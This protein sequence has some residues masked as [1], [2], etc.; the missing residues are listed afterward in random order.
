MYLYSQFHIFPLYIFCCMSVTEDLITFIISQ[1]PSWQAP[2][3]PSSKDK[4][5]TLTS[6]A[7]SL[8][9]T[10]L[11]KLTSQLIPPLM[12]QDAGLPSVQQVKNSI[13][14]EKNED[15]IVVYLKQLII[16]TLNGINTDSCLMSVIRFVMPRKNKALKKLL[17][18]YWEICPKYTVANNKKTLKH[19]MVL[20]VNALQHDLSS[21]NEYIRANTLRLIAKLQ[22]QELLEPL[23]PHLRQCLEHR[24]PIVKKLAIITISKVYLLY[25]HLIP[26]TSE[27]FF[28]VL[29]E[30]NDPIINRTILGVLFHSHPLL[31]VDHLSNPVHLSQLLQSDEN[32]LLLLIQILM[33]YS[34]KS[35]LFLKSIYSLLNSQYQSVQFEA[36]STLSTVT[37][38]DSI[39]KQCAECLLTIIKS[40]SDINVKLIVLNELDRVLNSNSI[41]GLSHYATDVLSCLNSIDPFVQSKALELS[42]LLV[43]GKSIDPVVQVLL[44]QLVGA[45]PS[46][47][48]V[49]LDT[50]QQL[51]V[52]YP[53]IANGLLG[54]LLQ[55]LFQESIQSPVT[56]LPTTST[57]TTS[58]SVDIL[59]FI[60]TILT[61]LPSSRHLVIVR[62][63]N[64]FNSIESGKVLRNVLWMLSEF[65][66]EEQLELVFNKIT[67]G[68]QN[69]PVDNSP[70]AATTDKA[71]INTTNVSSLLQ[72]MNRG[73]YFTASVLGSTL[74]KL[75]YKL[76]N[77]ENAKCKAMLSIS[78]ILRLGQSSAIMIDED[79]FD[80][81]HTCLNM[82]LHPTDE[83]ISL[84][85]QPAP[86][87][88][89][90]TIQHKM[91]IVK[92][93]ETINFGFPTLMDRVV[94]DA[95]I[96][97]MNSK[98]QGKLNKIIQLTGS[99]DDIYCETYV[100]V[101]LYDIILD[102]I[103]VNMTNKVLQ[104]VALEFST[105]GDL[106][107]I[108]K[109]GVFNIG[110][111]GTRQGMK[112]IKANIKVS[113][114]ETGV[115]FGNIFY[116]DTSINLVI[117]TNKGRDTR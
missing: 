46:F 110:P 4:S 91:P 35:P 83:L 56:S 28:N 30:S 50:L 114:T 69:S 51:T 15:R 23:V 70:A 82:L 64:E 73:D 1:P 103:I 12:Y 104:N 55:V 39:I 57:S 93:F 18:L 84:M 71:V 96:M 24:H 109:P 98:K 16:L 81:L 112:Q 77:D 7:Q 90:A 105:L 22:E 85:T 92:A 111:Y 78:Y 49:I 40:S 74:V 62:L 97:Q 59:L 19:E 21:A 43:D 79:S 48:Q 6:I 87:H 14:N 29:L 53:L 116:N 52:Q 65:S 47:Q 44:G 107:L 113:S 102:L 10:Q 117:A 88:A 80:H 25:N 99:S 45:N 2:V 101:Q 60:Q 86:D 34:S 72:I 3:I 58:I 11:D 67:Q 17:H 94:E 66:D 63:M 61:R 95:G 37:K 33:K 26:D 32:T 75:V 9:S 5:P 8:Q 106:K 89:P 36:A 13:E 20:V 108:E 54:V 38:S 68:L 41:K 115:I 31:L 42:V 100:N 27:L 76:K